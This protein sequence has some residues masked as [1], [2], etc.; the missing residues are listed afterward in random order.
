MRELGT[1]G[2]ANY[3]TAADWDVEILGMT[4][5]RGVDH[6]IDIGGAS[7][8]SQS[9]NAVAF[10]GIVSVVG[11]VGG[12]KAQIDVAQIFQ[13]NVT[14]HGIETGSRTMFE[15]MLDWM[16]AREIHPIVG[17]TFSFEKT[18]AAFF[19]HQAST[20]IGKTCIVF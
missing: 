20:G 3:R 10:G 1:A 19:H 12:L 5:G 18:Q 11:L 15:A 2:T 7:T 8:L 14:L 9:L 6:V 16:E 4:D 13:K 17:K